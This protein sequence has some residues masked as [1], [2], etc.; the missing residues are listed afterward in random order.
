MHSKLCFLEF[1]KHNYLHA[2]WCTNGLIKSDIIFNMVCSAKTGLCIF[3]CVFFLCA[4]VDGYVF[5][6]GVFAMVC[7]SIGAKV[8]GCFLW[9]RFSNGA[10]WQ[11]VLIFK[12]INFATK[13]RK[14]LVR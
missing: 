12:S 11:P 8:E 9:V 4:K 3:I 7:F 1:D 14:A 10:F 2:P 13:I 6:W 5:C